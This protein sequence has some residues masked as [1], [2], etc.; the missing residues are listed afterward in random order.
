M[1]C[2]LC[3]PGSI[4][5]IN[6]EKEIKWIPSM[7]IQFLYPNNTTSQFKKKQ[8]SQPIC[9]FNIEETFQMPLSLLRHIP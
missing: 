3:S 1:P 2:N 8:C 4:N 5:Y 9:M 6:Y 7:H